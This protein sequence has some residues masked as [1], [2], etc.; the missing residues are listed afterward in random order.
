MYL[1]SVSLCILNGPVVCIHRRI[2]SS[3]SIATLQSREGLGVGACQNP[4]CAYHT[5]GDM[6]L[7][8][9][10]RETVYRSTCIFIKHN[11]SIYKLQTFVLHRV[12]LQN[13]VSAAKL[14]AEIGRAHV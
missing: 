8:E 1:L 7:S 2:H 14:E 9:V 13:A 6:Q 11:N 4:T 3:V 5:H 10:V 12:T